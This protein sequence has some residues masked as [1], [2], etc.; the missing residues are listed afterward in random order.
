MPNYSFFPNSKDFFPNY[1]CS[2]LNIAPENKIFMIKWEV[3]YM[4]VKKDNI[5]AFL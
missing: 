4:T 1:I 3:V 5:T 2:A